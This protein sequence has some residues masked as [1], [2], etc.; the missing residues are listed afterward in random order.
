[1][2]Q[3]KLKELLRIGEGIDVEFKTSRTQ[4]SKNALESICAFFNLRFG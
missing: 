3:E 4:L 2:T 1:M